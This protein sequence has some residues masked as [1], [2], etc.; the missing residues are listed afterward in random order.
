MAEKR[1][2]IVTGGSR[3]IGRAVAESQA[4]DGRRVVI[5]YANNK[6]AADEVVEGIRARGGEAIALQGDVGRLADLQALFR[7]TIDQFER[8]DVLVNAAGIMQNKPVDQMTE[9]LFDR[10]FATNVK[11]TYFATQLAALHMQ[12]GGRIVNFSSSVV[13]RMAPNYSVYAATKGA[14]EQLT[15]HLATELAPRQIT[16]NAVAPGPVAT[17]MFTSQST[18]SQIE[19]VKKMIAFHRLGEPEDIARVVLFLTSYEAGWITGQTI[20]ANGGMN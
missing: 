16:I 8:L 2:A 19:A 4:A 15:R 10:H 11:G 1:T 12:H 13:G 9:E 18:P 20:R 17:E 3:G 14:V 7:T 6:N 5:N